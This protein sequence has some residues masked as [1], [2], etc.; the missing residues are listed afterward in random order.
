MQVNY[1]RHCPVYQG[2][3]MGSD[4]REEVL[5]PTTKICYLRTLPYE[6]REVL[7][8]GAKLLPVG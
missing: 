7:C 5:G 2:R 3:D 4:S 6:V 1:V 8:I